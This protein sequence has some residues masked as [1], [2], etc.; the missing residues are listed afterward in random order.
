MRDLKPKT[1]PHSLVK[2]L[3]LGNGLAQNPLALRTLKQKFFFDYDNPT[4]RVPVELY[5]DIIEFVRQTCYNDMNKSAGLYASGVASLEGHFQGTVGKI[6]KVA[7]RVLG[8]EK[9]ADLYLK[10]QNYNYPFGTH[11]LEEI[12]KGFLRYRRKSVATPPDFTRGTLSYLIQLTGGK[13]I[14]VTAFQISPDEV[15]YEAK[16]DA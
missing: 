4:Q 16:W 13:N 2:D 10:T 7:A 5:V 8:I 9:A 12:R 3:V 1:V 15:I 6:N 11:S 14:K